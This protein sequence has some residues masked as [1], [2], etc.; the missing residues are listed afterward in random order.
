MGGTSASAGGMGADRSGRSEANNEQRATAARK[1]AGRREARGATGAQHA[2]AARSAA[3]RRKARAASGPHAAARE[4][5]RRAKSAQA[6][7]DR[8]RRADLAGTAEEHHIH[9]LPAVLQQRQLPQ[10]AARGPEARVLAS[11]ARLSPDPGRHL[12]WPRSWSLPLPEPEPQLPIQHVLSLG[13]IC[14]T[15]TFMQQNGLRKYAGPFDWVSSNALVVTHCIESNFRHFLDRRQ[16]IETALPGAGHRLYDLGVPGALSEKARAWGPPLMFNHHDPLKVDRDHAHFV[17]CTQRFAAVA[18]L[19]TQRKLLLL[20]DKGAVERDRAEALFKA[21]LAYKALNFELLV[22]GLETPKPKRGD[23]KRMRSGGL[24]ER[25]NKWDHK[26]QL[27]LPLVQ[28]RANRMSEPTG[29]ELVLERRHGD[30]VVRAFTLRCRSQH[31]GA[32]FTDLADEAAFNTLVLAESTSA[33]DSACKATSRVFDLQ[34][35]P[36]PPRDDGKR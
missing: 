28:P 34:R 32:V 22:I 21:L 17:R 33:S 15:A 29:S 5:K 25:A 36:L 10:L 6:Q 12:S 3:E 2:A 14:F 31:T 30:A 20:V 19:P 13:S 8:A 24:N 16:Y 26:S 11:L 35:D 9:R 7:A 1:A 23:R 27:Q 4:S 18:R